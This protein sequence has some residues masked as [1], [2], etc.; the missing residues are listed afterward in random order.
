[1]SAAELLLDDEDDDVR[2]WAAAALSGL[3]VGASSIPILPTRSA[4][5]AQMQAA[6]LSRG[7]SA[8]SPLDLLEDDDGEVRAWAELALKHGREQPPPRAR[9]C[10]PSLPEPYTTEQTNGLYKGSAAAGAPAAHLS[11]PK[12]G[13]V[14]TAATGSPSFA[15]ALV[16]QPQDELQSDVISVS[17][18]CRGLNVPE[19]PG[20][21]A[22][23]MDGALIWEVEAEARSTLALS[24]MSVHCANRNESMPDL[25]CVCGLSRRRPSSRVRT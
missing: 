1:M 21:S 4:Q 20:G 7:D 17:V 3:R 11:S 6:A 18:R 14:Q 12:G 5:P 22:W 25:S 13:A 19:R 24:S 2:A 16:A 10:F 15:E 23:K 8:A 9:D